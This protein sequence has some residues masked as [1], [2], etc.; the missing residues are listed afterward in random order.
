MNILY[1]LTDNLIRTRCLVSVQSMRQDTEREGHG[2]AFSG[3]GCDRLRKAVL[4]A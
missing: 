2:A 3:S 4:R 1:E